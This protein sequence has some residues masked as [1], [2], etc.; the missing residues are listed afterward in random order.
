MTKHNI[1]TRQKKQAI[2]NSAIYFVGNRPFEHITINDIKSHAKVS[3]VTI[4]KFFETKDNLLTEAIK[5]MSAIAVKTTMTVISSNVISRQRLKNYF[6]ASFHL[7]RKYPRQRELV[8]YIF[9]NANESLQAYAMDLYN[10]T[11]P[12]LQRLY[13]DCRKDGF[14]REEISFKN[15]LKLCDMFT[16]VQPHFYETID[17]MNL[18]L[19]SIVRSF[20]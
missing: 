6:E 3:Q 9:S 19:E 18:L 14:I 15:F 12:Q 8:D 5:E 10:Q 4:Y 2:L 7:A 17:D 1:R 11:Y 13:D 20:G 16:V